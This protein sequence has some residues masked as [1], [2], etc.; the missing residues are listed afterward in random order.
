MAYHRP[1]EIPGR[2]AP[3]IGTDPADHVQRPRPAGNSRRPGIRTNNRPLATAIGGLS[4]GDPA[5]LFIRGET[6][7]RPD[8]RRPAWLRFS[9]EV[10]ASQDRPPG[11]RR[12][13]PACRFVCVPDILVGHSLWTWP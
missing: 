8:L 1:R 12:R 6:T 7:I 10:R 3:T 9:R 13:R 2:A 4:P 5:I 11:C